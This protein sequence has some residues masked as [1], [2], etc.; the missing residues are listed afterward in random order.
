MDRPNRELYNRYL[1][2]APEGMSKDGRMGETAVQNVYESLIGIDK[3][4]ADY[5]GRDLAITRTGVFVEAVL[6]K[7]P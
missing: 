5:K 4:V 7:Y 1:S 6:K 2:K 3:N